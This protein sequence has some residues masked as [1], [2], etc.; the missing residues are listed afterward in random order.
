MSTHPSTV[1]GCAGSRE[2]FRPSRGSVVRRV[3]DEWEAAMVSVASQGQEFT[4]VTGPL[5]REVLA[6]CY[7]P[8]IDVVFGLHATALGIT[9]EQFAGIMNGMTHR[10][11]ATSLPELADVATFLASD[12]AA[13]M[14]GTV[15]NLTGGVI[16]D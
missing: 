4:Q 10:K 11:R 9:R 3:P 8:T 6:H 5:R 2:E 7:R 16:V 1:T 12:R 13:A 14:T 15:A